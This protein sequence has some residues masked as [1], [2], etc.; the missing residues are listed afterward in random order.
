MLSDSLGDNPHVQ[1][2]LM[3]S[4]NNGDDKNETKQK[5]REL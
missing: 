3:P 1:L 2:Y 4:G 5:R